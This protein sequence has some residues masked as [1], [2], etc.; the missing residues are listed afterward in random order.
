[1]ER[2]QKRR[3]EVGGGEARFYFLAQDRSPWIVLLPPS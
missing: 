1:V 3:D 2:E